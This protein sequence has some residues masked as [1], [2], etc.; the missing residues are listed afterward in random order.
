VAGAPDM[1]FAAT[2]SRLVSRP[3]R[4][5]GLGRHRLWLLVAPL[6]LFFLVFFA[7]PVLSMF[8]ISLDRPVA[9]LVTAQGNFTLVNFIRFFHDPYFYGSIFRTIEISVISAFVAAALGYP[10]AYLI[11]KTE[12]RGR[13]TLLM[14]IVLASMQLDGVIRLYGMMV[15]MGDNGLINGTLIRWHLIARPL[16]LMYNMFGVIV[17][18]VQITLPFMVLSLIGII[19]NIPTSL[20]EAARSLGASRWSSFRTV[21]LPLSMPGILA[22]TLLVFALASSTYVVPALM[23]GWKVIVLPIHIYEQVSN[24]AHFQFGAAIAVIFFLINIG[25]IFVYHAAASH[26]AGGRV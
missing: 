11:A 7:L 13:V 2:A 21:T 12:H 25:A 18:D 3:R 9:G 22:G 20:E 8:A 24:D 16:P 6:G 19:R 14:I 5:G 26:T 1:A 15:L 10:L 23:G 17:G 4:R